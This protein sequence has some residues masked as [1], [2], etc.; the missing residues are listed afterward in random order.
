MANQGR[1]DLGRCV[2]RRPR[3]RRPR[4]NDVS[5]CVV[6]R[7]RRDH[8]HRRAFVGTRGWLRYRAGGAP[9]GARIFGDRRRGRYAWLR[10]PASGSHAS[11]TSKSR[12]ARSKTGTTAV[13]GSMCSWP[14]RHDTGS[15]RWLAGAARTTSCI[16]EDGWR[17]SAT[18]SFADRVYPR[19]TERS[20]CGVRHLV[21]AWVTRRG[22]SM[23]VVFDG[24]R[25]NHCAALALADVLVVRHRRRIGYQSILRLASWIS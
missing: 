10:S 4:A 7:P 8:R 21:V 17:C 3:A 22:D 15:T 14:R 16:P 23:R 13:A 1:S 9:R 2:R 11:P 6:H 24:Q 20:G 19:C 18:W 5:R 12:R 25:Q